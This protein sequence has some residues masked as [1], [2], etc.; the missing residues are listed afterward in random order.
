MYEASI[1]K[2]ARF[3]S[4]VWGKLPPPAPD[5]YSVRAP[6]TSEVQTSGNQRVTLQMAIEKMST[7]RVFRTPASS[8]VFGPAMPECAQ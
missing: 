1:G 5:I 7:L 4:K 6:A 2:T 8:P 3:A